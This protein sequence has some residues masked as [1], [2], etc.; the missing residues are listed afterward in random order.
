MQTTSGDV[1][2]RLKSLIDLELGRFVPR[3]FTRVALVGFP[4]HANVGDSAIWLGEL[5]Y[6]RAQKLPVVYICDRRSYSRHALASR[7]R[8]DG[9][10]L[11]H[12]GGNFGDLWRDHNAFRELVIQDF[13]DVPIIQL[14]QTIHFSSTDA[15]DRSKR[16]LNSHRQLTLLLRDNASLVFARK[17]FDAV[18]A[19]CPDMAF[20]IGEVE[21]PNGGSRS[22][23]WLWRTDKEAPA[24]HAFPG[25]VPSADVAVVDWLKEPFS[26][27]GA[28]NRA[29]TRAIVHHPRP[30]GW[31]RNVVPVS[32]ERL[33]TA[34]MARGCSLLSEGTVVVTNRLHA[35]IL[36]LLMGI[37]H[38][39]LDNS[40][41]KV[42][43]FVETWETTVNGVAFCE[44]VHD[45]GAAAERIKRDTL[46]ASQPSSE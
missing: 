21:R 46:Q 6:C 29:M 45:A 33:A 40:Y 38:V 43:G 32:F 34:R 17:H 44:S 11:L 36:C 18:S 8:D 13:L 1:V 3:H 4:N 26:V 27:L 30:C 9:A 10:I 2:A 7:L 14:P 12:G 24:D 16:V 20:S 28:I 15:L 19:L 35:H 5:Q 25:L 22:Q 37:P 42:R 41:G 31:L 23:L 39:V